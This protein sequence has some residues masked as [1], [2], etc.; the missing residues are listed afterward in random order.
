MSTYHYYVA[1]DS[2]LVVC[3]TIVT[4]LLVS[5]HYYWETSKSIAVLRFLASAGIFSY[6]G[7]LI[8]YQLKY[9]PKFPEWNPPDINNRSD[10]ALLLPASCFLDPDL[11]LNDSPYASKRLQSMTPAQIDRLG[12]AWSSLKLPEVSFYIVLVL[13]FFVGMLAQLWRYVYSHKLKGRPQESPSRK[14]KILYLLPLLFCLAVD[15]SC[16]IH[17]VRL[18]NWVHESKW[19]KESSPKIA[20]DGERSIDTTGQILAIASMIWALLQLVDPL[21]GYIKFQCCQSQKKRQQFVYEG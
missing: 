4:T 14:K 20:D 5:R 10:S 15:I 18:R 19:M 17:I 16:A 2:I 9:D 13:L 12:E 1:L 11:I 3:S 7:V 8:W 6:L 21:A